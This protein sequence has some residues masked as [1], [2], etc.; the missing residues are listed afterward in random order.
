MGADKSSMPTTT[1]VD[2][3][4]DRREVIANSVSEKLIDVVDS[5]IFNSLRKDWDI[6]HYGCTTSIIL[7]NDPKTDT[8]T[9]YSNPDWIDNTYVRKHAR[10]M[11]EEHQEGH[12][13]IEFMPH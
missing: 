6:V 11:N 1:P 7:R 4:K 13:I 2:A 10:I 9:L 3:N 5:L 8:I 12:I